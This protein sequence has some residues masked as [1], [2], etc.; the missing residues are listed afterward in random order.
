MEK[1][2]GDLCITRPKARLSWGIEVPFDPG[3][4]TFVWFDAL[5]NYISFAPGYDP[6]AASSGAEFQALWPAVH[7]IGKDILVP[8]HG[9]LLAD[10]A[11]GAGVCG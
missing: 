10:H 3:V 9:D 7:V 4:V 11:E 8:A 5:V 6:R 2:E 1:I